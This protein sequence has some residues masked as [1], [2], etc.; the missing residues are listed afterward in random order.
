MEDLWYGGISPDSVGCHSRGLE[1]VFALV[2]VEVAV[3]CVLE[4]VVVFVEAAVELFALGLAVVVVFVVVDLFF[5]SSSR[6][7][8]VGVIPT[9]L[10]FDTNGLSTTVLV[11]P[12]EEPFVVSGV[13]LALNTTDL[14]TAATGKESFEGVASGPDWDFDIDDFSMVSVAVLEVAG[15]GP[16]EG[17]AVPGTSWGK[18][19]G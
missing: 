4:L 11:V 16:F 8:N 6:G 5:L 18:R 17:L 12:G 1:G 2:V 13:D 15:E 7:N 10:V 9:D 14:S 3:W 19:V